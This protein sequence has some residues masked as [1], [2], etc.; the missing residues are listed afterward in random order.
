MTY[1]SNVYINIPQDGSQPCLRPPPPR[2]RTPTLNMV[3]VNSESFL[4]RN[5]EIFLL[6][7]H[8]VF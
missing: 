8:D 1:N 7:R 2:L 4:L 6:C 5:S 3:Q